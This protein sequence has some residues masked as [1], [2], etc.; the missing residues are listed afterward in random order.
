MIFSIIFKFKT[1]PL[2][3]FIYSFVN[4]GF[5]IHIYLNHC[6]DVQYEVRIKTNF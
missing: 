4:H 6:F 2:K 1:F 3:N 5:K